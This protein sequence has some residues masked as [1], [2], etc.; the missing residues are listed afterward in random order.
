MG[1]ILKGGVVR[2]GTEVEWLNAPADQ[3]RNGK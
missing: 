2:P 1:R 3:E